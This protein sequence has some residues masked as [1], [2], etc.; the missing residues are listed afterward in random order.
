MKM[1]VKVGFTLDEAEQLRRIVG[2]KKVDQIE[3]WKQKIEDKIKENNLNEEIGEVLWKVAEDSANY[4]FNRSHSISYAILAGWTIYLKFNYPQEFFLSLLKSTEFEPD[5]HEV[6]S[7]I[8]KEL[9]YFDIRLLQP[10]LCK[11]DINF[12]IEKSD[13]RYG[14]NAI[15]GVSTKVLESLLE[16]RQG[17]FSNKYEI[18]MTAKECGLNI[19]VLSALIQAGTLD[20][21]S[22]DRCRLVLEAQAFNILTDREKIQYSN[23]GANHNYDILN[24]IKLSIKDSMIGDDN[25]KIMSEKRFETFKKKYQ[26]YKEIYEKNIT[27][28]KFANW[29]F[30]KKLLGYSYSYNIRDIFKDNQDNR[31]TSTLEFN[32]TENNSNLRVVGWVSESEKRTSRNG[33]KYLKVSIQDE[34]GSINSMLMD[35]NQ[36]K[37]T[38]YFDNGGSVPKKDSIVVLTGR[39]SNDT[40]FLDNIFILDEKIYMKMSELK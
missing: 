18:F 4:S 21:F 36:N 32:S 24:S 22:K 23:I 6:I 38:N 35:G 29:Y 5:P 39:K 25:K 30:E 31:F 13:I 27:H 10:D 8:S 40:M 9:P 7:N 14:L 1:A 19:G 15:K 11:S 28:E 12:K 33:N 16:F 26:P 20:S 34:L 37:M 3:A 17:S 2:K